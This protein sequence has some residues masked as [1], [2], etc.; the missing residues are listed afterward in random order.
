NRDFWALGTNGTLVRV[1]AE[2]LEVT[3]FD[4]PDGGRVVYGI[5]LDQLGARWLGGW[6]GSL[7]RF[8]VA[9]ATWE[10]R[11]QVGGPSRLRGLAIDQDGY[12]WI[13]GNSPCGL[14]RYDTLNNQTIAAQI[15]LPNCDEPVG[16]SID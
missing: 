14:I 16:V 15:E 8:D 7:W 9:T 2:T 6:D 13:A 11:G 5:A 12:A 3:R 4:N 10:D 1:D